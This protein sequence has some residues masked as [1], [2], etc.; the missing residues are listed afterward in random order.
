LLL[1]DD[2]TLLVVELVGQGRV[3]VDRSSLGRLT[4]SLEEPGR[5]QLPA[6]LLEHGRRFRRLVPDGHREGR[7][8]GGF[9]EGGMGLDEWGMEVDS[10]ERG[11]SRRYRE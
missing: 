1:L 8:E 4:S 5:V 11:G 2:L 3:D 6:Q 10:R 9:E 7:W